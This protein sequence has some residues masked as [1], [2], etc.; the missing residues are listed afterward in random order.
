MNVRARL[1]DFGGK[2]YLAIESVA[3]TAG[4]SEST[5]RRAWK[6]YDRLFPGAGIFPEEALGE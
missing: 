6:R 1:P 4:V 5:V 3:E 2:E